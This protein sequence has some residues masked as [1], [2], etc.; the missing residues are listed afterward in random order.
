[1]EKNQEISPEN[2]NIIEDE[3]PPIRRVSVKSHDNEMNLETTDY[4]FDIFVIGGGSGGLSLAKEAAELGATVGLANYVEP[5]PKGT[6][7]GLGGTCVNVGCIPKKMIHFASLCGTALQ[8]Q[9]EAGWEFP[10]KLEHNWV[11]MQGNIAKHIKILNE[12]YKSQLQSRQVTYFNKHASFL[13]KHTILVN[14]NFIYF[15]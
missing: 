3:P 9:R 15:F 6:K 12:R 7:W 10:E 11:R 4:E 2:N 13:D 1:M 5:S 14:L 8:D